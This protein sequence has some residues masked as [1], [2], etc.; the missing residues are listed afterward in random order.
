M[1][2]NHTNHGIAL[3]CKTVYVFGGYTTQNVYECENYNLLEDNWSEI[4]KLPEEM[5]TVTTAVVSTKVYLVGPSSP[6]LVVF[7]SKTETYETL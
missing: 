1:L 7:D 3:V 2:Y 6:N 5:Q 4:Q